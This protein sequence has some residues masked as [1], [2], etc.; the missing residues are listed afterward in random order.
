MLLLTLVAATAAALVFQATRPFALLGV[1]LAL[2]LHPLR[3]LAL[4]IAAIAVLLCVQLY[5][6]RHINV[7]RR[8]RSRRP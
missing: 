3:T 6:W 2:Y 4:L 7:I 8:L 1:A 5:P